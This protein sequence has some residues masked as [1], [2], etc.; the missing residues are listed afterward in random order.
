DFVGAAV[1]EVGHG[2]TGLGDH[3]VCM[4]AGGIGSAGV[5]VVSTE[6]VGNR[7]DDA[8]RN[9]GSS[10]AVKE[11]GWVSVDGLRKRRELRADGSEVEGRAGCSF[12]HGHCRV[13]NFYHE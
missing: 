8:L 4:S 12:D 5:G 2:G 7:I 13:I 10:G 6:V 1:Q 11:D 3:G 9:L